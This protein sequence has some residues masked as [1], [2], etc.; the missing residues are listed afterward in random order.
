MIVHPRGEQVTDQV[1]SRHDHRIAMACAIFALGL[2][3]ETTILNADSV[4]KSF[5]EF[6][7]YLEELTLKQ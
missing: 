2:Q 1:S 6:Y 5:P 7:T 3:K 4:S